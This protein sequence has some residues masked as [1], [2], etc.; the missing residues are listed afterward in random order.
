MKSNQI[1]YL[2]WCISCVPEGIPEVLS[3][4]CGG[5]D[6]FDGQARVTLRFG[7]F[8][9]PVGLRDLLPH[10]HIE[11]GTRLVTKH[12]AGI[13]VI[14]LGVD[15]ESATEVHWIELMVT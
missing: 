1:S 10:H 2:S 8:I 6:H 11:P 7:G 5:V 4:A 3:W 9:W 13:I 12:E 15:E 14:P